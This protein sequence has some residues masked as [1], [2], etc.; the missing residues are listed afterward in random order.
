MAFFSIRGFLKTYF[1]RDRGI[2]TTFLIVTLF[3]LINVTCTAKSRD[4]TPSSDS[5]RLYT[6]LLR[7]ANAERFADKIRFH[8]PSI[9]ETIP[10]NSLILTDS[11]SEITLKFEPGMELLPADALAQLEMALPLGRFFVSYDRKYY[12]IVPEKNCLILR[13]L[14]KRNF[15]AKFEIFVESYFGYV[16]ISTDSEI[17][18][19][20]LPGESVAGSLATDEIEK[21]EDGFIVYKRSPLNPQTLGLRIAVQPALTTQGVG[22]TVHLLVKDSRAHRAGLLPGD[23]IVK[24]DGKPFDNLDE[25]S[26]LLGEAKRTNCISLSI[27]RNSN[28]SNRVV[29]LTSQY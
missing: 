28:I 9:G 22:A 5:D 3:T 8:T 10:L 7:R 15:L 29:L 13:D 4:A 18:A 6:S 14:S 12:W 1:N 27:I 26:Q 16:R 25:F 23:V 11:E 24:V 20:I 17:I 19:Q 21:V 2:R